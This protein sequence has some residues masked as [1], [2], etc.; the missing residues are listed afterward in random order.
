M[1]WDRNMDQ[2]DLTGMTQAPEAP[3]PLASLTIP[4]RDA[5]V[6]LDRPR[7]AGLTDAVDIATRQRLV[8]AR[9]DARMSR[10][11]MRGMT[12]RTVVEDI[13]EV[14]VGIP[15][16]LL[17]HSHIGLS[18]LLLKNDRLRG[19]GILAVLLGLLVLIA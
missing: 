7:Y 12:L 14:L 11:S 19:I 6:S 16:D 15:E 5:A 17:A 18:D 10:S 9:E 8:N 3:A 4:T 2:T 13:R 1:V